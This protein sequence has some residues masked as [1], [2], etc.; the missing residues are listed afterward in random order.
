MR[1]VWTGRLQFSSFDFSVK[2]Y[3]ATQS[4]DFSLH[5]LHHECGERIKHEKRCTVHG[6]IL[7]SEIDKGYEYEKGK[8]VLLNEDEIEALSSQ[9]ARALEVSMFVEREA[10]NPL[11]F[12]TPY[13]MAPEGPI[14]AEAY[15]TLRESIRNTGKYGIAK[16]VMRRKEYIVALWVKDE[17]IVVSTLRYDSEVRTTEA[18]DGL[19]GGDKKNKHDIQRAV[20]LI[21]RHTKKFYHKRFKDSLQE[22]LVALIK[23]KVAQQN[24]AEQASLK[25][26]PAPALAVTETPA[27]LPKRGLAKA[28]APRKQRRKTGTEG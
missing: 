28:P 2:I 25:M 7:E 19:N 6:P 1:A 11:I 20:D 27:A 14:A 3:S 4:E 24:A 21:E 10:L 26:E 9:S 16:M 15:H 5:Q 17:A 18:L 23:A 22:K 8:Y 12:D 13:Y